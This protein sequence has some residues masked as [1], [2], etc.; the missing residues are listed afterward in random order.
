MNLLKTIRN[1]FS[2]IFAFLFLLS[3]STFLILWILNDFT[4]ENNIKPIITNLFYSTIEKQI[5]S[6]TE[7]QINEEIKIQCKESDK[8]L[9][10]IGGFD[11][12]I[13]CNNY[14]N[15]NNTKMFLAKE[16]VNSIY[17]K[18]YDCGIDCL[19]EKQDFLI[20][21]KA[22]QMYTRLLIFNN[23]IVI[24][25]G[26]LFFVLNDGSLSRKMRGLSILI[27]LVSL[28]GFL[29]KILINPLKQQL[30][31]IDVFVDPIIEN[32]ADIA[33]KKYLIIFFIGL[34]FLLLSFVF[35]LSKSNIKE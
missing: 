33:I 22:H 6:Y 21:R 20:S 18:N 11:L 23:I 10:P 9:M 14:K 15:S 35:S 1:F 29:I 13:S 31:S 4:S 12:N 7:Q 2:G 28:Q 24:F 8:I 27:L 5:D 19:F 34:C 3:L 16:I 26:L 30:I 32:I 25:F 17:E